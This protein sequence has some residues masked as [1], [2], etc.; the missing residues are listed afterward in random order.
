MPPSASEIFNAQEQQEQVKQL[1]FD[2]LSSQ[3]I[4]TFAEIVSYD[5]ATHSVKCRMLPQL[6]AD[7]DPE[8]GISGFI[9]LFTPWMGNGWGAQFAPKV[10]QA[11]TLVATIGGG[12]GVGG[13]GGGM[14]V[15]AHFAIGL[16]YNLAT[17][18]KGNLQE[19][20]MRLVHESGSVVEMRADS[21]I[22]VV[23]VSGAH[24]EMQAD[25]TIE[26]QAKDGA[27]HRILI[28]PN[29]EIEIIAPASSK[30]F[31]PEVLAGSEGGAFLTL[32]MDTF[33]QLYNEHRHEFQG[34]S[35]NVPSVL[36]TNAFFTKA[37]K[38]N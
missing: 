21:S 17:L 34:D 26:I 3:R 1:V 14:N 25:S 6:G 24:I 37:L 11:F 7:T 10:G 18:P 4:L 29:G 22:N 33:I 9:P 15:G 12:G 28:S 20:E 30:V 2:L 27:G 36:L 38:G 5:S 23:H 31:A 32:L 16:F 13:G 35:T 19:G 8:S